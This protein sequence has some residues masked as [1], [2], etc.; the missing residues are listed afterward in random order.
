MVSDIILDSQNSNKCVLKDFCHGLAK[1]SKGNKK[2]LHSCPYGQKIIMQRTKNSPFPQCNAPSRLNYIHL[3]KKIPSTTQIFY[4]HYQKIE[5]ESEFGLAK[6]GNP[7][8]AETCANETVLLV[9]LYTR[10]NT[11]VKILCHINSSSQRM[12][13]SKTMLGIL[14]YRNYKSASF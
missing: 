8:K 12:N 10:V 2:K 4:D 3:S 6:P 9:H 14:W 13:Y 7:S 5:F 1:K 11:Q